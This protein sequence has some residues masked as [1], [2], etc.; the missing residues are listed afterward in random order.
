M[1]DCL[2][3]QS[4]AHLG[5]VVR[6]ANE[7][8]RPLFPRGGMT[9]DHRLLPAS[10]NGLPLDLRSL[11]QV[12]DYP[13]QDLTITVQ[14]G[15]TLAR[16]H[17]ILAEQKQTVPLDVPFPDRATLGGS[18]AANING[19]RRSYWGTWR[20]YIIGIS[21]MNELGQETKAG[22]RVVKNVAGYDFCKLFTGSFGTLGIITQVT[23]K[24]R[25]SPERFALLHGDAK[26]QDLSSFSEALRVAGVRPTLQ[27]LQKQKGNHQFFLGFE[28]S[29]P[30]VEWQLAQVRE[31]GR[32]WL[33]SSS[34][35]QE[36]SQAYRALQELTDFPGI[37][38][39]AIVQ[40]AVPGSQLPGYLQ[41]LPSTITAYQAD[42]GAGI[43]HCAILASSLETMASCVTAMRESAQAL[44]GH[45]TVPRCPFQWQHQL[46]AFG[47]PRPDWWMM[48]RIKL[49]LD[50]KN[51]YQPG[52]FPPVCSEPAAP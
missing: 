49:A 44:G 14:A 35:P 32:K 5:E 21:W 22:G 37:Q 15:M 16:L 20:D 48:R 50:P 52:R 34:T 18:I 23:L 26:I 9:Q 39:E 24:V 19:P 51:L 6:Q 41:S 46:Q 28:E 10:P 30:A 25:P 17:A 36:G 8:N 3:I 7:Q 29:G 45:V 33:Q 42:L 43:V 2:I 1:P 11:N 4:V 12:I 13:F 31:H 40:A 27:I 38:S 47:P